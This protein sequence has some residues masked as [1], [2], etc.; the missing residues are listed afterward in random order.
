MSCIRTALHPV[1]SFEHRRLVCAKVLCV[2]WRI[3]LAMPPPSNRVHDRVHRKSIRGSAANWGRAGFEADPVMNSHCLTW[4][5]ASLKEPDEDTER[6]PWRI[7]TPV[8]SEPVPAPVSVGPIALW[9]AAMIAKYL[10]MIEFDRDG[11]DWTIMQRSKHY[12]VS[13]MVC[14]P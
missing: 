14:S 8:E 1:P 7:P 3:Y 12:S 2:D 13:R 10:M 11:K 6:H 9:R 4:Q 5:D